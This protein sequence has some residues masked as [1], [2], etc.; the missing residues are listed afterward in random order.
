MTIVNYI[1]TYLEDHLMNCE[2]AED[3]VDDLEDG[4][5]DC[6][7]EAFPTLYHPTYGWRNMVDFLALTKIS[8]IL[9]EAILA[10]D[11]FQMLLD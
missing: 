4:G 2:E 8:A 9:D 7:L 10:E 3:D 11:P 1:S 5:N 6:V